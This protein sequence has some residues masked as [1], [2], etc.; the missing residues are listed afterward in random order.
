MKSIAK[1]FKLIVFI[2]WV[3]GWALAA[4]ALH[5]VRSPDKVVVIPKDRLGFS[6]TYVDIRPWTATD[7]K[8]HPQLVARLIATGKEDLIT[9]LPLVKEPAATPAATPHESSKLLPEPK[10]TTYPASHGKS[11]FD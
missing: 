4:S 8:D 3:S 11:I 6:E 1:I 2:T 5:V 10:A 7:A 9:N